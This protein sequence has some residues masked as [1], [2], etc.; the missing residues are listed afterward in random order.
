MRD[1]PAETIDEPGNT[2][3]IRLKTFV[4]D[5]YI[6]KAAGTGPVMAVDWAI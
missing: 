3:K 1:D 4:H 2:C 6:S 5:T